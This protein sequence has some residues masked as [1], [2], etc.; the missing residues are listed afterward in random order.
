MSDF[1]SIFLRRSPFTRRRG[2][3]SKRIAVFLVVVAVA[4]LLRLWQD[5][6]QPTVPE[7]LDEGTYA[8]RRVVDGDTLL[9][10]N[11]VRI[12]LMGAD[13]PETVKPNHPVEPFG[14]EATRFTKDFLSGGR[15]FLTFDRQKIN[16]YGR[17]LA[18]AWLDESME[19]MLNEELI[20]VGL[21][22][23]KTGYR[24]SQSMK[25]R[26]RRAED[27]AKSAGRG[28]WSDKGN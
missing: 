18:Y 3:G 28:I 23:A 14:S 27:E 24:Y 13:T 15:V 21:A 26:F 16:R 22:T 17:F 11:G 5:Q 12:R 10:E 2:I 8:V 20:R 7:A 6:H 4:V 19:R 9:L 25:K 1:V